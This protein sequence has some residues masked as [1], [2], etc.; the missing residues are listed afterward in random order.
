MFKYFYVI[1]NFESR[2]LKG[3]NF[4]YQV[5]RKRAHL[6][7]MAD[8]IPSDICKDNWSYPQ[9]IRRRFCTD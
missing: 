5:V 8:Y 6:C 2:E 3:Y 9:R 1:G 4:V 7:N